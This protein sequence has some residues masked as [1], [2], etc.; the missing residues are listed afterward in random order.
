MRWSLILLF[1]AA[2]HAP[3]PHFKGVPSTRVTVA[4]ATFD[5]RVK[6]TL[7]EAIRTNVQYAPRLGRLADAGRRA[8]VEVTGCEVTKITGDQA[9]LLAE[10]DCGES[11]ARRPDG[12][13]V[14]DEAECL[15]LDS[16]VSPATGELVLELDC[17]PVF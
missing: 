9:H 5:V 2:C 3:G 7:A 17:A 11:A 8:V 14:S 1:L 15:T 6:G 16:Y 4:G 12:P 13:L 10:L